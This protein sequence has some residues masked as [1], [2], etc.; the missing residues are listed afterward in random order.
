MPVVTSTSSS[1]GIATGNPYQSDFTYSCARADTTGRGYLGFA[2]QS[3]TDEQTHI[4]QT[5]SFLQ[6][7]PFIGMVSSQTKVLGS[8]TLNSTTNSY[9]L[10]TP[11]SSPALPWQGSQ[12]ELAPLFPYLYQSVVASNDLNGTALPTATTTYTYDNYGNALT[13]STAK[14]LN[15]SQTSI[16]STTNVY[17]APNL[18]QWFLGRLT[19]STVTSTTP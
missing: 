7:I 13:V 11:T 6:A 18:T 14:T 4:V 5:S 10:L 15:G 19:Q 2:Q 3:V 1:T 9:G 12:S 16:Q 17:Q 8:V